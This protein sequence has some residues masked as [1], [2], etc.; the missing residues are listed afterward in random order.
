MSISLKIDELKL[1]SGDEVISY[2]QEAGGG[3][4]S[5]DVRSVKW[6]Y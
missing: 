5:F 3:Q 2:D 4:S 6:D 1:N